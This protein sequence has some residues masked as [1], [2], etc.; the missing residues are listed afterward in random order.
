VAPEYLKLVRQPVASGKEPSAVLEKVQ[1]P[2]LPASA[3]TVAVCT[4]DGLDYSILMSLVENYRPRLILDF[5]T[6]PRFD[7]ETLNRDKALNL[8]EN[9]GATYRDF[10]RSLA[11]SVDSS[12]LITNALAHATLG[13]VARNDS[14]LLLIDA[15]T[16]F[17]KI[18]LSAIQTLRERSNT[19]WEL[20][21]FGPIVPFEQSRD[22]L[23]V[24]H[25]NPEDNEFTF[26]LQTQ[27]T[28]TGYRT[29]SD[30]T[31]LKAGEVFWDSIEDVIRNRAARV[32]A[33]VSRK[34]MLKPSVLDE[35]SLA[36]SI[37]RTRQ[38]A[39]FVIPVRVDDYPFSEV[40][41]NI[42]R[43]N[44][45]D[46]S[47]GWA[48]GL[49]RLLATLGADKVPKTRQTD[50]LSLAQWWTQQRPVTHS[51]ANKQEMLMSN[52][53][54]VEEMPSRI[55]SY[56]GIP[57]SANPHGVIPF[58]GLWLSFMSP[59]ELHD[60][61][62]SG[63]SR[64]SV[65]SA[66]E[67]FAGNTSLTATLTPSARQ[68]LL[69]RLL[70]RQWEALLLSRGLQLYAETGLYPTPYIPDGLISN[71]TTYFLDQDGVRRRRILV[72][73]SIKRS[74]YWHLAPAGYFSTSSS[75]TALHLKLRILFSEDGQ[76]RWP[77]VERM[78]TTRRSF[79]KNWWNDRWR[80]LQCSFMSWISDGNPRVKLYVGHGGMLAL[81]SAS[82]AYESPVS[83]DEALA[84][85][86]DERDI[87]GIDGSDV[88][89]DIDELS[90]SELGAG[91]EPGREEGLP[92]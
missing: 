51:I 90:D 6:V 8:F 38:L 47:A 23:F 48:G 34:S 49:S 55:Y 61:Q 67:L 64:E 30:L 66:P 19:T 88:D 50:G 32:I 79:C 4:A 12:Q 68:K 86:E 83:I 20:L 14:L 21:L 13:D 58:H 42:F 24:S 44:I 75:G 46:F 28:R 37:E 78:R 81:D 57:V 91:S 16:N 85:G 45:V 54:R 53:F 22:V 82:E 25:A 92:T 80:S 74:L 77:S 18:G 36:V 72:G 9:I 15:G 5:R 52:R 69:H 65:I 87:N 1:A 29:W 3:P 59:E 63:I 71:N 35:I 10:G 84:Q 26:W 40:P 70:N 11:K 39:G 2:L 7:F 62:I 41:A 43:K 73:Q 17:E 56:S 33:V 89:V 76:S 60:A 31:D 27:L